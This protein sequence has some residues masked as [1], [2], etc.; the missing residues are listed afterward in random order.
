M[1]SS[2]SLNN[3]TDA[4]N[5][6]CSNVSWIPYTIGKSFGLWILGLKRKSSNI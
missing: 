3:I 4:E 5:E 1:L 2:A 6:G